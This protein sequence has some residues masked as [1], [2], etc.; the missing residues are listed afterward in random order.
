MSAREPESGARM[1]PIAI[2][3]MAGRFPGAAS[4]RQHWDNLRADME[5]I[6][7]LCRACR[8]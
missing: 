1:E 7:F 2:V 6:T 8:F 4:L 5:S 3:G